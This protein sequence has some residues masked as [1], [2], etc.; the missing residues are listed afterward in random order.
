MNAISLMVLF[1]IQAVSSAAITDAPE[2]AGIYVRQNSTSWMK[3]QPAQYMKGKTRGLDAYVKTDG[4]ANLSLSIDYRGAKAPL[5]LTVPKPAFFIR[6]RG[7][8]KDCIIIRLESKKDRRSFRSSPS[9]A[10]VD[11]KLGFKK[12]DIVK[13]AIEERPDHSFFVTPEEGL[14]PG[15][16]LMIFDT[17]ASGYDFG[18]D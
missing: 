18:I 11:N 10:A 17:I 9:E 16:Y 7:S 2:S 3:L 14:K 5:R 4:D 12:N 15:E 6:E 13:L 1:L 8:A